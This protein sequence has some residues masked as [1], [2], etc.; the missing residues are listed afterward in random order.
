MQVICALITILRCDNNLACF[1]QWTRYILYHLLWLK[2][3]I[4]HQW[5][6]AIAIWNGDVIFRRI[7]MISYKHDIVIKHDMVKRKIA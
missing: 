4:Q 5:S 7:R 6:N 1:T 2:R 3:C